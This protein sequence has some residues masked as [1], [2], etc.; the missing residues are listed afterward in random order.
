MSALA[1][2]KLSVFT[3]SK[4]YSVGDKWYAD[5]DDGTVLGP[6]PSKVDAVS[7]VNMYDNCPLSYSLRWNI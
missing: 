3:A 2:P 5:A 4:Y 1:E 6:F 7:E